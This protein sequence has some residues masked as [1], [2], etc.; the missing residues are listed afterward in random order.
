MLIDPAE[1]LRSCAG[2]VSESN[3]MND[4]QSIASVEVARIV[5]QA[6]QLPSHGR[7]VSGSEEL[8]ESLHSSGTDG[9]VAFQGRKAATHFSDAIV[10][11]VL[12]SSSACG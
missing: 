6:K 9:R 10:L 3:P 5:V 7:D 12:I 1:D 4:L 8:V 2:H 11:Q